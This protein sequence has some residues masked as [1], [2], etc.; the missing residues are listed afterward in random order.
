MVP[1][2]F[3]MFCSDYQLLTDWSEII[4]KMKTGDYY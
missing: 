2:K 1:E 3:L 4:K